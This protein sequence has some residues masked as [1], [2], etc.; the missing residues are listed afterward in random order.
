MLVT[1]SRLEKLSSASRV[2]SQIG[3]MDGTTSSYTAMILRGELPQPKALDNDDDDN[4]DVGPVNGPRCLSSV[5]L[6]C[7]PG[8]FPFDTFFGSLIMALY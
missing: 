1:I 6:A 5:E 4:D 8:L 3:M 2:F 7:T